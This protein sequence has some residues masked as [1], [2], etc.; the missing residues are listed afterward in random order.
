M[1]DSYWGLWLI[2]EADID[3][4]WEDYVAEVEA[5]GLAENLAI[6]QKAFDAYLG[7]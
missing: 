3:E 5:A 2:G 1:T 4:T 7:K 6:R